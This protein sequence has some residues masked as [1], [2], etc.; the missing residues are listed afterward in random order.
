MS[1]M[2]DFALLWKE[3]GKHTAVKLFELCE[4]YPRYNKSFSTFL[5]TCA[6]CG[7]N[8]NLMLLTGIKSKWPPVYDAIPDEMG[9]RAY[10][11]LVAVL[12]ML[13]VC[14]EDKH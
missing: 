13:G 9:E 14:F 10:F 11:C 1:D 12:S 3:W 2:E 7:G 5:D 8:W 6:A 4:S